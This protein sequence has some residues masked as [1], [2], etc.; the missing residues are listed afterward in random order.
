M[1][2]WILDPAGRDATVLREALSVESLDLKAATDIICSRTPSQLQIMKQTYYAK[3]GT[4]LEHD[5]GQ[6]ASGDH[7]KVWFL[8]LFNFFIWCIK[9]ERH[10]E[11]LTSLSRICSSTYHF[12]K[13]R[14]LLFSSWAYCSTKCYLDIFSISTL[15]VDVKV[16]CYIGFITI[17]TS[18][19]MKYTCP[20]CTFCAN[21]WYNVY[22]RSY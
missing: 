20:N 11:L 21:E 1:L 2:L 18:I 22:F 14:N 7:Q 15:Y 13:H 16:V 6:Q 10:F 4:Y 17:W 5:I 8:S 3:F 19:F 9:V 12:L